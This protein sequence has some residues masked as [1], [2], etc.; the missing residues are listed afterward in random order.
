MLSYS[1]TLHSPTLNEPGHLVAGLSNWEYG[2]F[3]LYRVNPPI[4]RILAAIP[5]LFVNHKSDWSSFHD[6]PGARPVFVMGANF[7]KANKIRSPWIFTIARWAC[8]PI[9][10]FGCWITFRFSESLYGTTA[11]LVAA[12]LWC[13]SPNILAHAE[14]ITNDCSATSFGIAAI[15]FYWRWLNETTWKKAVPAAIFLALAELSKTTWIILFFIWPILWAIWVYLDPKS[16]EGLGRRLVFNRVVGQLSQLVSIFL[17]AIYLINLAYAFEGT[18]QPLG[19]YKF[20]SSALTGFEGTDGAGNRFANSILAKVPVPF[21]S[22]YIMGIDIQKKDFEK[23]R[24]LNYLNGEFKYGGWPHY[25]LY[26]VFVKC[27]LGTLILLTISILVRIAGIDSLKCFRDEMVLVCP[28]IAVFLL[29]STQS[30]INEHMRYA[31]PVIGLSIIYTSRVAQILTWRHVNYMVKS[32]VVAC[33]VWTVVSTSLSFPHQLCYFN[34]LAGGSENGWKHLLGSNLDWGQDL[35]F[36]REKQKEIIDRN[37]HCNI[38]FL[39]LHEVNYDP[40]DLGLISIP[41]LSSLNDTDYRENIFS[42]DCKKTFLIV[43]KNKLLDFKDKSL[44]KLLNID[45]NECSFSNLTSMSE[46]KVGHTHFI[47]LLE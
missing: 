7:I 47:Y 12:I 38:Q 31:L 6:E 32:A 29:I 22:N 41:D 35:L 45:V 46:D 11:G 13:F 19:Q 43:S 5:V 37:E 2:R 33:I 18:F 44:N 20:V 27:A 16:H 17:I 40:S 24:T 25:Y 34:E 3:D 23:H 4:P 30:E 15:Y 10:L 21:P 8:I 39:V 1:A 28:G 36:I 26:A 42:N 14:L 9:S